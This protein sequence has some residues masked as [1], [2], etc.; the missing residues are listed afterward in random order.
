M[1]LCFAD[2]QSRRALSNS[3]CLQADEARAEQ[4]AVAAKR[5]AAASRTTAIREAVLALRPIAE[6]HLTEYAEVLHCQ[7]SLERSLRAALYCSDVLVP[8]IMSVYGCDCGNF[9]LPAR[10]MHAKHLD[11]AQPHACLT[12]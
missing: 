2:R 8:L 9:D 1:H 11:L 4:M 7:R 12:H 6:Q 3:R 10:R 5:D